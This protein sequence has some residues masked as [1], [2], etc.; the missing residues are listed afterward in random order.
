MIEAHQ[1][2]VA[3]SRVL[4]GMDFAKGNDAEG[5]PLA[6]VAWF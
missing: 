3:Q 4:P 1:T 6:R 2:S 5:S